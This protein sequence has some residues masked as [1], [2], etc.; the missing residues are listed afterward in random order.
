MSFNKDLI[1]NLIIKI[2]S[3][4]KIVKIKKR[5]C[6]KKHVVKKKSYKM[7]GHLRNLLSDK[8]Q[9]LS[10]WRNLHKANRSKFIAGRACI[11]PDFQCKMTFSFNAVSRFSIQKHFRWPEKRRLRR[12]KSLCPK[13]LRF[14][15]IIAAITTKGVKPPGNQRACASY[16]SHQNAGNW[17]ADDL[18]VCFNSSV[19][20]WT[21]DVN[22]RIALFH[23]S[24]SNQN[25]FYFIKRKRSQFFLYL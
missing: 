13:D 17:Y 16:F 25:L 4:Y 7:P 19:S 21:T 12:R 6:T 5:I 18:T 14:P 15:S 2:F 24:L 1:T 8:K 3:L 11:Y 20:M 23:F 10:N 9:L 22:G